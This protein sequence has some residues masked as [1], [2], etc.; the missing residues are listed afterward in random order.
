MKKILFLSLTIVLLL[1]LGACGQSVDRA[2]EDFCQDL[3]DVAQAAMDLRLINA[4]SSKDDLEDAVSS[5]ER[6]VENLQSSAQ[7][8]AEAK[9]DGVQDAVSDLQDTL[10]DLPDG[11]LSAEQLVEAKGAVIETMAEVQQIAITVCSYSLEQ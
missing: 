2:K 7:D 3:G 9:V 10:S 8:V 11:D 1:S 5:L 4:T 6:A